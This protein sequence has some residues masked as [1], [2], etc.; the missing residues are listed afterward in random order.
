M[1]LRYNLVGTGW[2]ETTIEDGGCVI[3]VGASYHSD[4]LGDLVRGAILVQRG[5]PEVRFGFAE[6]PGEYRWILEKKD[7]ESYSLRIL[8]FTKLWGNEPDEIGS[9]VFEHIVPRVAYAKAVLQALEDVQHQ[10]SEAEYK[11][12]W[13]RHDFPSKELAELRFL[14]AN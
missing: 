6:E 8:E 7:A 5:S 14:I 2:S 10:Q 9:V 1:K 11:K 12:Q 4:A 13:V 3:K